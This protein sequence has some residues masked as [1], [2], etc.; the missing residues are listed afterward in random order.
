M[1]SA[2]PIDVILA[3]KNPL[4]LK[5]IRQLLSRDTRFRLAATVAD[6]K[7]FLAEIRKRKF[8]VAVIGWE[9]PHADGRAVL[10]ALR[11]IEGAPPVI[12]YTGTT[13]ASL[14]LQVMQLGGAG[15]LSKSEPTEQL[16]NTLAEV[17]AGRMVF[18]Y[19]DMRRLKLDPAAELTARE[20]ELLAALVSGASNRKL[21]QHFGV[22]L[23][24][25]KFHL[26]NV[27]AKL[28]VANRAQAVAYFLSSGSVP[29]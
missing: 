4:V 11:M 3:D 7:R 13:G 24:T 18:P 14:P 21:A 5:G 27:Y 10:E 8:D 1:T 29:G 15:F 9:M 20:R 17:A 26:K 22:S 25:V 12:V 19:I 6:G 28:N 23:H 2:A 16:L